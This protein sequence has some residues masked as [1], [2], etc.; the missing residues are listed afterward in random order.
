MKYVIG[1][2]GGGTKTL[3]YIANIW[4]R[5]IASSTSGPS[6][7]QSVGIVR[8][9]Q[10]LTNVINN[11]C[12]RTDISIDDIELLSLGM[13]GVDRQEDKTNV[14]NIIRSIGVKSE[15]ILNNDGITE[16]AGA[17]G[18]NLGII[19]ISGTGSISYGID[20]NGKSVRVGGWGNILGDEGSGYDIGR[21]ALKAIL[22]NYDKRDKET[23]LTEK[24]L[25]Y[26]KLKTVDEMIGYVY[27]KET[28]KEHI[29]QIAP[30]VINAA[31]EKDPISINIL[32]NATNNLVELTQ[33]VINQLEF[34]DKIN[35]TYGGGILKKSEYVQ[36]KFMKKMV[37]NN[38]KIEI[39]KPLFD[40]AIG[41]VLIAW[42]H[43]N[44]DYN[45]N[46]ILLNSNMK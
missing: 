19:T 11:L 42:D 5:I 45:I 37:T 3:G 26:L 32:D 39:S 18:K 41:A 6:N 43:L 8:T 38:N 34:K 24:V 27:K 10:S 13:A 44:V 28:T 25:G 30:V 17:I 2:D 29:A 15:I 16:L 31:Y 21:N 20:S 46:K 35:L 7:Y 1:I 33:T 40:G 12:K 4:G 14:I 23:L 36:N 22:R 9:K